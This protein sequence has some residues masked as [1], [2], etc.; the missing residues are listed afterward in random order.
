MEI[1]KEVGKT[2]NKFIRQ[3]KKIAIGVKVLVYSYVL[4][5]DVSLI[6]YLFSWCVMAYFGKANLSDLLALIKELFSPQ[7]TAALLATAMFFKDT[8]GNGIPDNMEKLEE[9]RGV[10]K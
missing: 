2:V 3:N 10:R 9:T 1:I 4:Y 6:I 5:V 7:T 8:N